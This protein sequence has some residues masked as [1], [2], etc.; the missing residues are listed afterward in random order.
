[1]SVTAIPLLESKAAELAQTTQI[2]SVS[3]VTIIDKFTAYNGDPAAQTLTV[4]MIPPAGAAGAANIAIVKTLQAG[5]TY[6]F[7]E[8]VGHIVGKGGSVGTAASKNAVINIRA[9]GRVIS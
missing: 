9:S 3:M 5:E 8:V 6:T 7:P 4:N 2:T 1:M